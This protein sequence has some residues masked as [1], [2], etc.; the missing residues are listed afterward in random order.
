[1]NPKITT[2]RQDVLRTPEIVETLEKADQQWLKALICLAWI[3]GKRISEL[4]QVK[5]SEIYTDRHYLYCRFQVLKKKSRKSIGEPV[6]YLKRKTRRHP[7][8]KHILDYLQSLPKEQEYLFEY[9][10][11]IIT[12]HRATYYLKKAN[13][14]A[15]FHLF[16]H[17]L[18]TEMA[19]RGGTTFE[20]L[21]WFDWER[22][23]TALRYV[24]RGTGL[25]EKWSRKQ[26][27]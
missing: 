21:D 4:L 19:E 14:Q 10:G 15:W 6:P 3:F 16:R 1:M 25:T 12:R 24:K 17:S 27:W 2:E 13:K 9:K 7:G 5:Q 26:T 20:L 18:A 23:K 22:P 8:V 11:R